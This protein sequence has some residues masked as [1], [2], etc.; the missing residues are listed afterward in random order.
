MFS[1]KF[2]FGETLVAF[3][4]GLTMGA[5]TFLCV[6]LFGECTCQLPIQ[7]NPQGVVLVIQLGLA[8]IGVWILAVTLMILRKRG[9]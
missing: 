6:L 7:L 4:M 5:I 9:G 2:T 3:F 8:S 1:T